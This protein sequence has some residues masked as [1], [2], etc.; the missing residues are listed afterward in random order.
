MAMVGPEKLAALPERSKRFLPSGGKVPALNMASPASAEE[1]PAIVKL[2]SDNKT[3]IMA[4]SYR[5]LIA[6]GQVGKA[7]LLA[8]SRL[9]GTKGSC[10]S[11]ARVRGEI[12]SAPGIAICPCGEST[13]ES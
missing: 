5:Y 8:F 7:I 1:A 4:F 13:I 2:A 11:S 6:Q 12:C 9:S 10:S 3:S